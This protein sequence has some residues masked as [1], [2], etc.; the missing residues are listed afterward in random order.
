MEKSIFC[1][2]VESDE[3]W[4]CSQCNAVVLK[5]AVPDKPFAACR[6]GA[7][8][9]GVPF[10][11]VAIAERKPERFERVLVGPGTELKKLISKVGIKPSPGCQ[12]NSH[13]VQMNLWGPDECERKIDLIVGWLREEATRRRLPFVDTLARMLVKRAISNARKNNRPAIDAS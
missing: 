10:R 4:T 1:K 5:S 3:T 6:V 7:E 2:W 9:H 8:A 12:C 13:A 11:D